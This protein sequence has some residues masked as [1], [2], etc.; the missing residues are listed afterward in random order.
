MNRTTVKNM[1]FLT[2]LGISDMGFN[3]GTNAGQTIP[4]CH[5][6]IIP[7]YPN[8]DENPVGGIRNVIPEKGDYRD[9]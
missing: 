9:T 6:P 7:R 2:E 8:D 1:G 5:L 3:L 4:H